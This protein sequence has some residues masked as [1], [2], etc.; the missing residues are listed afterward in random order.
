MRP[1]I[2]IL[3]L[4]LAF[5]LQGA[6]TATGEKTSASE[7]E[8]CRLDKNNDREISFEEFSA[9]EFYKLEHVRT[10]PYAQL[11]DLEKGGDVKLSDDERGQS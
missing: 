11:S 1:Y 4:A 5:V 9:C 10:L 8:F 3:M 2:L 6:A 7:K